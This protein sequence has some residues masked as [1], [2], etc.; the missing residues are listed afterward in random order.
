MTAE[1]PENRLGPVPVSPEERA[2]LEA[3]R[4]VYDAKLKENWKERRKRGTQELTGLSL[5]ATIIRPAE[6]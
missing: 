4:E 5:S 2:R 6:G 1:I 3:Q